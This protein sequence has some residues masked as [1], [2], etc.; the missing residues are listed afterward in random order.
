MAIRSSL[1][2]SETRR[3]FNASFQEQIII[4]WVLHQNEKGRNISETCVS[5]REIVT[6]HNVL[7]QR[8][9]RLLSKEANKWDQ[10][11]VRNK[12]GTLAS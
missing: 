12:E 3:H 5:G 4:D 2:R 6:L 1:S 8:G 11:Q 10:Q 7:L 9:G